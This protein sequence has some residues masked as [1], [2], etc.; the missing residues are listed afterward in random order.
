LIKKLKSFRQDRQPSRDPRHPG[1]SNWPEPDAIRR[2]FTGLKPTHPPRHAVTKFPRA[3]FGLP[4][5]FHFKD[6]GDPPP[7]TLQ[8]P[9]SGRFASPL[10]LRPICCS[11]GAVGMGLILQGTKLP[12]PLEL[13]GAPA[14]SP[15]V[16]RLDAVDVVSI[17][18]LQGETN[19]LHAFLKTLNTP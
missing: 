11:D 13:H 7:T 16:T 15:I 6:H 14:G 12:N 1:L 3:Q 8:G 5:V 17:P 18:V 10:L 4:I 19:V 2:R 9:N